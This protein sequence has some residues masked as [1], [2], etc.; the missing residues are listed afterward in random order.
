MNIFIKTLIALT[1]A[2]SACAYA[3]TPLV[4]GAVK[5]NSLKEAISAKFYRIT[6]SD[7][8][9]IE[10]HVYAEV[11][12]SKLTDLKIITVAPA[13]SLKVL[14]YTREQ[15]ATLKVTE[16]VTSIQIEGTM[17]GIYYPV[18]FTLLVSDKGQAQLEGTLTFDDHDGMGL[19]RV[20]KCGVVNYILAPSN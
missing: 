13:E 5:F 11:E 18:D 1:T 7:N 14:D 2:Y 20:M 6:C 8:N 4:L 15:V 3:S 12:K 19:S 16:A 17:K 9:A 10:A